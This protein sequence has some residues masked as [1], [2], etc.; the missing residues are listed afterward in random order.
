MALYTILLVIAGALL[1]YCLFLTRVSEHALPVYLV[2][3]ATVILVSLT[4]FPIIYLVNLS[5]R[6][7]G[8]YNFHSSWPFVGLGNYATIIRDPEVIAS[9]FRTLQ[10]LVA[11]IG[12]ELVLGMCMALILYQEFKGRGAVTTLLMLPIMV[13][14][15]LV[16]MMWRYMFSFNDGFINQIF[17]ALG[18][19]KLPWLTNEPLPLISTILGLGDPKWAANTLNL[20]YGLASIVITDVWQWTPFVALLVL[21]GLNALPVEPYEAAVVDGASGWAI[22][23]HLTLPLLRPVIMVA[24]LIR[25]MDAMKVFDT[26]WALFEGAPFTRVLNISLYNVGITRKIYGQGAAL[27]ILIIILV[28]IMAQL[29]IGFVERLEKA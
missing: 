18:A 3:P 4:I 1:L 12:L 25:L 2:V 16:G 26:I 6:D 20:N 29:V 17:S 27:S 19:K 9:F 8:I 13:S 21:A 11:S 22:F 5:I 7:V 28:T 24:L 23:R 10:F 15:I 14:P